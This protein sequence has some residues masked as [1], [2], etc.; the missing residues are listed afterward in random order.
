MS[1]PPK[2]LPRP[3]A[4]IHDHVEAVITRLGEFCDCH[5]KRLVPGLAQYTRDEV[6]GLERG[7]AAA[8]QK[9]EDLL[10]DART[11]CREAGCGASEV[12][13]AVKEMRENVDRL[14]AFPLRAC[15]HNT[16][17]ESLRSDL[18][19]TVR[20]ARGAVGKLLELWQEAARGREPAGEEWVPATRAAEIAG[21]LR[22]PINLNWFTRS[23]DKHG[24][25]TRGR[26]LPGRHER[27]VE[28][29]SLLR[30]LA[31]KAAA[32]EDAEEPSERQRGMIEAR[33]QEERKH[34][35]GRPPCD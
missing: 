32:G 2:P 17:A 8:V 20:Y 22:R 35:H 31:K 6:D 27:E 21:Q 10:P 18:D 23:A 29:N 14:A 5:V 4:D 24:V 34:K 13:D 1:T 9:L 25:K 15:G 3:L 16:S 12:F 11:S 33:M 19:H 30:Y 7:R 28:L 26:Q